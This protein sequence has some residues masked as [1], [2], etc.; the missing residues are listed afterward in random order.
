[1]RGHFNSFFF[2][3]FLTDG[4]I[5][6]ADKVFTEGDSIVAKVTEID[7]AKGRFLASLRMSDCYHKETSSSLDHLEE[8]VNEYQKICSSLSRQS[9]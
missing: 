7:T 3:Q 4:R 5:S 8:Y 1:M 6:S 2:S 9:G